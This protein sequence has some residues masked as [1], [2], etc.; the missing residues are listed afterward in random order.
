MSA[1]IARV[2]DCISAEGLQKKETRRALTLMRPYNS[3]LDSVSNHRS[4]SIVSKSRWAR[5]AS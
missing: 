2:H 5:S 3:H 1:D 4:F